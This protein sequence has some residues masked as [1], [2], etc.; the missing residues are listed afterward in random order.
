M[1]LKDDG[2][3]FINLS[4]KYITEDGQKDSMKQAFETSLFQYK[5]VPSLSGQREH[6]LILVHGR[7]G[8]LR[9]LDFITKRFQIVDLN[10]L[11]VQAPFEERRPEQKDQGFSWYLKGYQGIESSRQK[12]FQLIEELHEYG[13][14]Y[15]GIYWLG[16]SQGAVMGLD[17]FVRFPQVLGGLQAISGILVQTERVASEK[18]PIAHHQSI[19]ITHGDRDEIISLADAERSYETLTNVGIPFQFELFDKPHSFQMNKELP[20]L[21]SKLIE[22]MRSK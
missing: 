5:W 17:V 6:V 11:I 15:Q 13:F 22:W 4:F 16:F 1:P 9:V 3:S 7:T 8:N 10:F 14:P 21:E 18:S 20:F 12:L 2:L 19:L